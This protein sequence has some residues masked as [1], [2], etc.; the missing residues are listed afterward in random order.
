MRGPIARQASLLL[1]L[2][3]IATHTRAADSPGY[4]LVPV[5]FSTPETGVAAGGSVIAFRERTL[6]ASGT[7]GTDTLS[8]VGFYT[9]EEQYLTSLSGKLYLA[10]G[11]WLLENSVILSEFPR[12]Y[13]G[14]GPR[15]VASDEESYTPI[16]K[17][18]RLRLKRRVAGALY[19][20]LRW[21]AARYRVEEVV[22]DGQ[23]EAYYEDRTLGYHNRLHG[24]G[25]GAS[26]DTRDRAFA[27]TEG[28]HAELSIVSFPSGL[29]ADEAFTTT[30][31]DYRHYLGITERST[32]ALQ[33]SG[34]HTGDAAP[35][36]LQPR[37]GGPRLRGYYAGRYVDNLL[38]TSQLEARFPLADRWQG[39]AFI[40]AGDVFDSS[41][42]ITSDHLKYG[43]GGGVRYL[44]QR[45]AGIRLRL[46]AARGYA[47]GT[48]EG[49][50]DLAIYFNIGEA[51]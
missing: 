50:E 42:D 30:E 18:N 48:A 41:D 25:L 5:I 39:A 22:A 3:L 29:G 37:L 26:L 31:L 8:L 51:F 1:F 47:R 44:L 16:R 46:D 43:V 17:I 45:E 11:Q 14:L 20:G 34:T 40:A 32:A 6:P 12:D 33:V 28:T 7:E 38:I 21:D 49:A 15:T 13:F 19:A 23:V 24:L 9:A 27:P 2:L 36:P 10:E 35:L 4:V